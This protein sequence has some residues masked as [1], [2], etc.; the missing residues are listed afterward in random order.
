L[1][2]NELLVFEKDSVAFQEKGKQRDSQ[3][4]RSSP[5]QGRDVF[6]ATAK[7]LYGN[8]IRAKIR[9]AASGSVSPSNQ[10]A[11]Q[12]DT[13]S[14]KSQIRSLS[15]VSK[16]TYDYVSVRASTAADKKSE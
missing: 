10:T 1:L 16:P 4:I 8:S 12:G 2:T 13:K 14:V 7:E 3:V 5:N 11:N 15:I 6:S 9:L